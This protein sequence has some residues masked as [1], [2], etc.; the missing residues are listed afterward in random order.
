[1]AIPRD[2]AVGGWLRMMREEQGLTSVAAATKMGWS[3]TKMS[4]IEGGHNRVSLEDAGG[5][6]VLYGVTS[7]RRERVL[8]LLRPADVSM[9]WWES[10]T[11]GHAPENPLSFHEM[12]ATKVVEWSPQVI[13]EPLQTLDYARTML[14]AGGAALKG[15]TQRLAEVER[16]NRITNSDLVPYEVYLGEMALHTPLVGDEHRQQLGHLFNVSHRMTV[17]LVPQSM[18]RIG[19][20]DAWTMLHY[21]NALNVAR[22]HLI[23]SS[24]YLSGETVVPYRN[25]ETRLEDIALSREQSRCLIKSIIDRPD[26]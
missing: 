3:A 21:G 2:R 19:L 15:M 1:M 13:P 4:R 24:V 17:R 9:C 5:L 22:V 8:A 20:G 12:G 11:P 10:G 6:L 14:A 16:R 7:K 18:L 23:G 26:H 25:A